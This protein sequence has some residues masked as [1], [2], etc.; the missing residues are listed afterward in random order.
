MFNITVQRLDPAGVFEL[1]RE[2]DNSDLLMSLA[3]GRVGREGETMTGAM[4]ETMTGSGPVLGYEHGHGH[5]TGIFPSHDLNMRGEGLVASTVA[6]LEAAKAIDELAFGGVGTSVSNTL[7][8]AFNKNPDWRP[9]FSGE[10]HIVLPT[11]HGLT[12]ANFAGP[13]T[14]LGARVLRG[15]VG[16]DGPR[17]IDAAAKLHDIDYTRATTRQDIA[18]ADRK[19]LRRVDESTQGP[20]TKAIVRTAIRAKTLVED[21]GLTDP[22]ASTRLEREPDLLDILQQRG[23]GQAPKAKPKAKP[24]GKPRTVILEVKPKPRKPQGRKPKANAKG[25]PRKVRPGLKLRER[26]RADFAFL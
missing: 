23:L 2:V 26:L 17:G 12:R 14:R 19:F 8:L 20:K 5:R 1:P 21:I 22:L 24:K 3:E 13:G 7:S 9:G 11:D 6:V 10:R 16:V 15:D 4:T 18:E 25:K